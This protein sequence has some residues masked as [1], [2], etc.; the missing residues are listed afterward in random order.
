VNSFYDQ[1]YGK[2]TAESALYNTNPIPGGK[3]KLCAQNHGVIFFD[4]DG[5]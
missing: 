5:T 4:F 2:V 3:W 1:S